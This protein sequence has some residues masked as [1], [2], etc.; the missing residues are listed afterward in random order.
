MPTLAPVVRPFEGSSG[1]GSLPPV[2]DT[3]VR[4][5][6]DTYAGAVDDT[7]RPHAPCSCCSVV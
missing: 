7:A 6:D 2:D 5:V 4:P 1:V 3:K